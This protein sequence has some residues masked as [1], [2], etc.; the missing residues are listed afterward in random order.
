MTFSTDRDLLVL[1]PSIFID[2]PFIA[3][4]RIRATDA[5]ITGIT[6]TSASSNF[7]AAQIGAGSVVLVANQSFEVLARID[8]HTLTISMP[9]NSAA[10]GAIPSTLTG[11]NQPLV[12][13]TFAPQAA[14][15]AD[16]LLRLVGID[17]DDTRRHDTIV[18]VGTMSM[19]ETLGTLERIYSAATAINQE[20]VSIRFKAADYR[21]RFAAACRSARVLIDTDHDG[22]GDVT[23]QP[24]VA[25]LKR[26]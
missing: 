25:N 21:K 4:Q 23:R 24:G 13:R 1:E 15:V 18:S 6:L 7:A 17:P 10:D 5:A 19:L 22:V 11:T 16:T 12:A 3:Q 26:V 2:M 8:D 14:L 20:S 9:R